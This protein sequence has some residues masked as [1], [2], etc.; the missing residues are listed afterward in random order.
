MS[1]YRNNL[2][3]GKDRLF[4]IDSG[5]ETTFVFTDGIDL[6]AFAA[7]PLIAEARGRQRI[8]DYYRQHARIAAD[9]G[10]GFILESVGWRANRDWG[11][12]LG[13]D[14]DALASFNRESIR[15]LED[16]RNELETPAMPVVISG[17]VG[18]RG[19]GYVAGS[20]MSVAEAR[21]YHADQILTYASTGADQVTAM[22]MTNA[23]EAA[24]IALAAR[25]ANIP[26]AISFTLETDGCLPTG[27]SL[28]D[29]IAFVED[30]SGRTPAYY[31]INCAH[32][33]HFS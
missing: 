20:A 19:D 25:L 21:G 30:R 14:A 7:Y 8:R 16:L 28:K 9:A 22:T 2:P 27:Q 10:T 31:M 5:M 4:L 33:D 17:C 18:P 26:V 32:P 3:N 29:A 24:G 13:H 23:E 12:Q 15:L 6:P 1:K 11:A